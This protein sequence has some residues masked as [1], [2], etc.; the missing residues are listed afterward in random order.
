M[1]EP[2]EAE[3]VIY[4]GRKDEDGEWFTLALAVD[5]NVTVLPE[6][7]IPEGKTP[8][9]A[10]ILPSSTITIEGQAFEGIRGRIFQIP[11]T[12]TS[13]ADDAFDPTAVVI[14]E[15]GSYAEKRCRELGL[16]VYVKK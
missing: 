8:V 3:A 16:K 1:Y 5:S 13:I 2:Q 14:V 11:G 7:A 12:V 15:A 6:G 10:F 4:V 9:P